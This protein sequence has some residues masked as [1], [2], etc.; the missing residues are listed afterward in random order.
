[1]WS[2]EIFLRERWGD[3]ESRQAYWAGSAHAREG[4]IRTN[5]RPEPSITVI[6]QFFSSGSVVVVLF[7]S[8]APQLES[9]GGHK[10]MI[11]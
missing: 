1:M 11:G 8:D 10:L 7:R 6:P 3:I 4:G 9:L 2:E 5:E